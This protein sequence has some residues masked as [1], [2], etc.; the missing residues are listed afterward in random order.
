MSRRILLALVFVSA[1]ALVLAACTTGPAPEASRPRAAGA[2]TAGEDEGLDAE[3]AEHNEEVAERLEALDEARQAG[4]VGKTGRLAAAPATGWVGEH[5]VNQTGDD[6]EPAVA[7]DP[8]APYVYLLHN[9]YGGTPAC[10]AN[11]PDPAM[12]LHVSTDGGSTWRADQY[13][14]VCKKV[15]G[16]FDPIIEVVPTTGTVYAVWMNDYNIVFSKSTNHGS[17]WS[18]PVPVYGNVSFGDKPNLAMSRDGRNVYV[19]FNGPTGGDVYAAVSHDSGAT[20]TQ[21]RVT[22]DDRYHYDYGVTVLPGGRVL[23]RSSASRTRDRARRQRGRSTSTS[24]RRTT[25]ARRGP[26]PWS[27]RSSSA[28]RARRPGAIPSSTT[29]VP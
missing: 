6:W 27:T 12:I 15:K 11:C 18:T 25:R 3:I 20:W 24:T 21:V 19:L 14:C 22:N 16:Q 23:R 28:R 1:F 13:I 9:R 2:V 7:T 29:A 26:T 8:S 10:A 5:L 17:T 4:T